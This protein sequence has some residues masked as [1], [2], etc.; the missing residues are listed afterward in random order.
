MGY[1]PSVWGRQAWHFIHMVALSYPENPSDDDKK[2]YLGFLNSL[3]YAL[4]C[5]ICGEH[6]RENMEKY[7]PRLDSKREFFEWTVDLHNAVNRMNKKKVISYD[8]AIDELKK[9]SIKGNPWSDRDLA[10]GLLMSAFLST[11]LVVFSYKL[12]NRR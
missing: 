11:L 1:N 5:P 2:H 12:A 3:Q 7:P 9:N 8:Q 10:K 6:F 4:P